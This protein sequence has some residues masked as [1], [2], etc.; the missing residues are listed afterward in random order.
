MN[1]RL[2]YMVG[3]RAHEIGIRMAPET[4]P[5]TIEKMIVSCGAKSG[6]HRTAIRLFAF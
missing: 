3:Q 2:A 4:M 6:R 1:H 5:S